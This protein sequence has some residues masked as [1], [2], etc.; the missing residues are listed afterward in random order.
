MQ[1]KHHAT[2]VSV[3]SLFE[4]EVSTMLQAK[5]WEVTTQVGVSGF[6]VDLGVI[7]PDL[8]ST[9]LA[10]VDADFSQKGCASG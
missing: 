9:F 10:G 5:G 8:P 6:R 1:A 3:D 7:D 2:N 4:V